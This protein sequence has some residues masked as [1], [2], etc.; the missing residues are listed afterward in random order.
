M[1]L[2]PA[3]I[4]YREGRPAQISEIRSDYA[5]DL[6]ERGVRLVEPVLPPGR[7]AAAVSKLEEAVAGWPV[8]D[9]VLDDAR[10][11]LAILKGEP[12]A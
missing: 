4:E 3:R 9:C 1:P 2:E 10:E 11:A 8:L 6:A 7:I 12:A 5:M